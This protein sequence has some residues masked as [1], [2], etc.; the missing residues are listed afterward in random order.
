M[1]APILASVDAVHA[2]GPKPFP[3]DELA[4]LRVWGERMLR[5]VANRAGEYAAVAAYRR[6][7]LAVQL[8]PD[9]FRAHGWWYYG[10]EPGLRELATRAPELHAAYVA[11]LTS[12]TRD[13]DDEAACAR[14]V[15][16]AFDTSGG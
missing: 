3:P 16:L 11:V 5:R 12:T 10:P 4:A 8:L 7:E 14:L 2:E 9:L 13:A 6:A 1:V 15:R